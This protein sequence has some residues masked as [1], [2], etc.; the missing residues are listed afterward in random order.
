MVSR[1]QSPSQLLQS[2]IKTTS[3]IKLIC[4]MLTYIIPQKFF[5]YKTLY[6]YNSSPAKRR[7]N[8]HSTV[9]LS[10]RL[11]TYA[12]PRYILRTARVTTKIP[13]ETAH[14]DRLRGSELAPA[15]P[16][17]ATGSPINKAKEAPMTN[18]REQYSTISA[19]AHEKGKEV[20]RVWYSFIGCCSNGT[21]HSVS[22]KLLFPFLEEDG[23]FGFGILFLRL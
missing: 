15:A 4:V 20:E 13:L 8:L 2:N 23:T 12:Q 22:G 16:N 7:D 1:E 21:G 14:K 3:N 5:G 6:I 10:N 18:N 17:Q 19:D 11:P 9:A